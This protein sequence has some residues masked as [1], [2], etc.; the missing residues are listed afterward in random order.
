MEE[1]VILMKVLL[2]NQT[3]MYNKAHVFHWNVEGIEFPQYHGFFG[4]LYGEL[5]SAI[6]PIAEQ[7]RALGEY[8]PVSIH[9]LYNTIRLSKKKRL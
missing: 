1:L 5:Y 7:I 6:D 2:A 4:E 9:E 3:F 8:A